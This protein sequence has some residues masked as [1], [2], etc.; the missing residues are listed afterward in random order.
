MGSDRSGN[1]SVNTGGFYETAETLK[2]FGDR[3]DYLL[4]NSIGSEVVATVSSAIKYS[5]LLVAC[6]LDST[7]GVDIIL[8]Y[9]KIVDSGFSDNIDELSDQ[10]GETLLISGSDVA[11]LEMKG[12]DFALD[13]KWDTLKKQELE[14]KQKRDKRN[15]GESA[16][17]VGYGNN[18]KNFKTDTDI[19]RGRGD[20][21]ERELQKWTPDT[22]DEV[23]GISHQTLEESSTSWDQFTVNEEKFGVKSTYDEHLYTTKINKDD[24]HYEKRLKEAERL[25]K[26]IESQGTSGNIHLAEERGLTI[27]DSGMDEEDLYSGVDRRGNDL[28]ASLKSN[29]KPSPSKAAVYVAPSLRNQPHHTDPAIISST[30]SNKTTDKQVPV[31]KKIPKATSKISGTDDSLM[32]IPLDKNETGMNKENETPKS[33]ISIQEE[34]PN[35]HPNSKDA[36]IEE[37]KKFAQKFKVPYDIPEDMQDILKSSTLK[38]DPSLPPKPLNGSNK[39]SLP[40][41]PSNIRVDIRKNPGTSKMSSQANT[42]IN[43][44]SVGRASISTKRR[45]AGSF[46]GSKIPSADNKKKALF[47]TKFNMFIQSRESYDNSM[48]KLK[49]KDSESKSMEPFFIEKPYFTAPTWAGNSE[50]SYKTLFPDEVTALQKAQMNLQKRQMTNMN[51]AAAAAAANQQ[52][53]LVM[54]N[55]M[56]FPMGPGA[57]PNIMS[58]MAAGN[59]GMYMPMQPQPMFYPSMPHMMSVMGGGEDGGRSPSPQTVSPHITPTYMNKGPTASSFGYPGAMPFQPMISGSNGNYRQN[60]HQGNHYNHNNNHNHHRNNHENH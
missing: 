55:M 3:F 34:S 22:G 24:P 40:P 36:Q 14:D 2:A 20:V 49:D 30:S 9:P 48:K 31:T 7:N 6:N 23:P 43:S 38:S 37:L 53:G 10:L 1:M 26:E 42:P 50:Q 12:V 15:Q 54:G 4:T 21:K 52:M 39:S 33:Q 5:G 16:N 25:A 28:L 27:D 45:G 60:Y 18:S 46:F 58:G 8:K 44:P 41:T 19:S 59:M 17:G 32:T 29:S 11:E 51:A 57:S 35:K 56:R 13:E 47:N